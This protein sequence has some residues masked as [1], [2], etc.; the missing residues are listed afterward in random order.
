MAVF[1]MVSMVP[2]LGWQARNKIETDYSGFSAIYDL[3]LYWGVNAA[4][5]ARLEG[6]TTQ[7]LQADMGFRSGDKYFELHPEQRSWSRVQMLEYWNAKQ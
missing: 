4:I 6:K 1:L 7:Q 3:N 2:I 5:Q